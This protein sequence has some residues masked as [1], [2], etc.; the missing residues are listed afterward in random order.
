MRLTD[1]LI[2][3]PLRYDGQ[4]IASA[5]QKSQRIPPYASV[6]SFAALI[7]I[8]PNSVTR[9]SVIREIGPEIEIAAN[10][11]RCSSK[12]TL[13]GNVAPAHVPHRQM[14]N[15]VCAFGR[16]LLLNAQETPALRGYRHVTLCGAAASSPVLR[17]VG[18]KGFTRTGSVH[19]Q[20]TA[21]RRGHSH[22]MRTLYLVDNNRFVIALIKHRHID[23]FARLFH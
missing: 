17:S 21:D 18:L 12:Y 11:S 1:T 13:Q 2:L 6:T 8:A 4:N 23:R 20:F 19:R 16:D 14:N 10:G 9:S 5:R 7:T 15:P 22:Q 3:L